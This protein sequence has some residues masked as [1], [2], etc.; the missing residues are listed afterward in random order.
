MNRAAAKGETFKI[1]ER[2]FAHSTIKRFDVM[3][4]F[5][6]ASIVHMTL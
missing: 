2:E 6:H 3:R 5:V 1:A 4:M